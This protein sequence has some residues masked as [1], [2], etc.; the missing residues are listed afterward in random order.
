MEKIIIKTESKTYPVYIGD[1]ILPE[2]RT[3]LVNKKPLYTKLMV[4]TDQHVHDL[5]LKTLLSHLPNEMD[6]VVYTTPNG[7]EAKSFKV[8]ED[9]ISFALEHHL[10]RRSCILAFGGGAVGDLA[11]F[12]AAT[13]M[14]GIDF[15]QIPTTILAH[16]SAVGGKVAI[17]HPLGK[18]LVGNF[19]QPELVIYD[20][21]LLTS[22]SPL[23]LRSGFAE[24]IKHALISDENFLK[25]IMREVPDGKSILSDK[26]PNMLMR[27][28]EV[29]A[30]VVRQDEKESGIRAYLNFGHTLGHA[31][32]ANGGF[33]KLTHG[34]AVMI[35]MVYALI[36][37][38][39]KLD[40]RFDLNSF[41]AWIEA[42]GYQ[43]NI[44]ST[45]SFDEIYPIM[46]HDKKSVAQHPQF[47]LLEEVGKPLLSEVDER[48][49]RETFQQ[50]KSG[51]I[52]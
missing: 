16:D 40:L 38:K 50:L 20:T 1:A 46:Q 49:L 28:I 11:G 52:I 47:V 5:H 6:T 36:L 10:D 24:L 12:V 18:N 48:L 29:K 39:K 8:F 34:E 35:G 27:G 44:P 13:F 23:Q 41:I 43:W 32:E 3:F 26:L 42:L 37:S 4:V 22:L 30:S 25:E 9:C 7:E 51:G 31:L 19:Y 33:H 2:L 45:L 21:N 15:I 14:R 17:N